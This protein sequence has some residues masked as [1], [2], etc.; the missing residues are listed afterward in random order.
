M[1]L[2]EEKLE[3][4]EYY[5]QH[6]DQGHNHIGIPYYKDRFVLHLGEYEKEYKL[7]GFTIWSE[8]IPD[9]TK[10]MTFEWNRQPTDGEE[11]KYKF[12][13]PDPVKKFKAQLEAYFD[14]EF[15][16][17]YYELHDHEIDYI[18]NG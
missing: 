7:F 2:P 16:E 4:I 12:T 9:R 15:Y 11:D 3:E 6:L 1:V 10:T 18:T 5:E 13:R 8:T 14:N 17:V